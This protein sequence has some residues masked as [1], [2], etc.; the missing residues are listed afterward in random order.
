MSQAYIS[1]KKPKPRRSMVYG[2]PGIGKS[3]I[4]ANMPSPFFIQTED[5]AEHLDVTTLGVAGSYDAVLQQVYALINEEHNFSSLVLDSIDWLERLLFSHVAK[6]AGMK[7]IADIPYGAGYSTAEEKC[8][9]FL[10]LLMR[11]N[12]ERSMMIM[13]IAH[14]KIERFND[15]HHEP[16]D[17]YSPDLHKKIGP[18][19]VEWCSDVLFANYKTYTSEQDVG[20]NKKRVR[21]INSNERVLFTTGAPTHVA[22]NRVN[23]M[24]EQIP[25]SWDAYVSYLYPQA[26]TNQESK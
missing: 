14:A 5:G 1:S 7:S 21:A 2:P 10:K 25:L 9:E 8:E 23:G 6:M 26:T 19:V 3:T 24:P 13:I 15:P 18:M 20:F 12:E 4:G 22:K 17:R 11:A 16:Y